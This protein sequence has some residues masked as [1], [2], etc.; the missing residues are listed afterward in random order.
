MPRHEKQSRQSQWSARA[1]TQQN[2]THTVSGIHSE[3]TLTHARHAHVCATSSLRYVARA[4]TSSSVSASGSFRD[5]LWERALGSLPTPLV[6]ALRIVELD[7][8]GVLGEY[9]R[10]RVEV[11]RERRREPLFEI[12]IKFTDDTR[13]RHCWSCKKMSPLHFFGTATT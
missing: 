3:V 6:D 2:T 7:D 11:L 10:E 12:G 9:P 4:C 13:C 8:R 1:H 5:V